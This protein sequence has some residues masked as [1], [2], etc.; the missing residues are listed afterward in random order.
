ML[1]KIEYVN[2]QIYLIDNKPANLA[3]EWPGKKSSHWNGSLKVIKHIRDASFTNPNPSLPLLG[4]R[5]FKERLCKDFEYFQTKKLITQQ[6]KTDKVTGI[7]KLLPLTIEKPEFIKKYIRHTLNN[8]IEKNISQ[9]KCFREKYLASTEEIIINEEFGRKKKIETLENRRNNLPVKVPGEKPYK[10]PEW[11][12]NFYII[13]GLIVGSTNSLNFKKTLVKG[14][15]NF[16]ETLNLNVKT[17]DNKNTWSFKERFNELKNQK[18]YVKKLEQWD[19]SLFGIKNEEKKDNDDYKS[20][21]K[22]NKIN[23]KIK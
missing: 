2:Q 11:T 22:V 10:N 8:K 6:I 16:Y 7:K 18:Q 15:N 13:G 4:R 20:I 9:K 17:L 5:H 19:Q 23:Y 21:K 3:G 12:S 1:Q 14:N